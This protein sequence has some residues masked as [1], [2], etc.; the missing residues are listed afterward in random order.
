MLVVCTKVY[1]RRYDKQEETGIGR[2]VGWEGY[3]ITQSLYESDG[4]NKK[5]IP[6]YFAHEDR[7]YI[8]IELRAY[9]NYGL[10]DKQGYDSS[11]LHWSYCLDLAG[12]QTV[13]RASVT[14]AYLHLPHVVLRLALVHLSRQRLFLPR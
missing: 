14:H 4:R 2:G 5:F 7:R 12:L 10:S 8:P 13:N 11:R 9:T 6:I 3:V 1:L